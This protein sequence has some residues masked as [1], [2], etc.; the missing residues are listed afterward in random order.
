MTIPQIL[1]FAVIGTMM[2]AFIWGR[3]RYDVIAAVALL[4]AVGVGIVPFEK[5]FSGFSDD[6]VIIVGSALV[7]SAAVSRSG[8]MEIVIQRWAPICLRRASAL[9]LVTVC[10]GAFRL[11]QEYRRPGDHDPDRIPVCATLRRVPLNVLMPMSFASRLGGLMTQIAHLP[12]SSSAVRQDM[13]GNSF[14]MFDFTPVGL[15][16]PWRY[17]LPVVVLLAVA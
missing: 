8:V 15:A 10:R 11:R 16:R 1:S 13:T 4:V 5:A 3:L 12:T 14:S 9:V 6:I 17:R 2:A 7:V